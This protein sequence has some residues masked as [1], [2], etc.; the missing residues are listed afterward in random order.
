M[1][2][3]FS[4]FQKRSIGHHPDCA[5][6]VVAAGSASRMK[7]IDKIMTTLSG[8]P[9]LAR[10]LQA[11]QQCQRIDEIV[12]VIDSFLPYASTKTIQYELLQ[13]KPP[14]LCHFLPYLYFPTENDDDYC[15]RT[16]MIIMNS[17]LRER[18]ADHAPSVPVLQHRLARARRHTGGVDH[19]RPGAVLRALPRLLRRRQREADGH[20]FLHSAGGQETRGVLQT[21]NRSLA[22][23]VFVPIAGVA[24]GSSSSPPLMRRNQR[25]SRLRSRQVEIVPFSDI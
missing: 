7:G 20:L 8:I 22:L 23:A 10:T 21:T 13:R 17:D 5:A 6:V 12:V 15:T 1:A 4:H 14:Q 24:E 3:L 25:C 18:D 11:L 19:P 2:G 9:V 16:S